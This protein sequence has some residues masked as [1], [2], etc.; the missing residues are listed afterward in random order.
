MHFADINDF[1][2]QSGWFS[3]PG[4]THGKAALEHVVAKKAGLSY[5]TF[6]AMQSA[7][8]LLNYRQGEKVYIDVDENYCQKRKYL[9][10]N[11]M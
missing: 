7:V 8:Y 6:A 9:H 5:E 2:S 1:V 4:L 3:H 10:V 11:K